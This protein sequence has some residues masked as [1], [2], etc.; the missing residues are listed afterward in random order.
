MQDAYLHDDVVRELVALYELDRVLGLARHVAVQVY[1]AERAA[2][3]RLDVLPCVAQAEAR[4]TLRPVRHCTRR[5]GEL[6]VN[7]CEFA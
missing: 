3:Q 6:V 7:R 5:A 4:Q 1:C 2:P